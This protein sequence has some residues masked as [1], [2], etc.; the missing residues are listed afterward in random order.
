MARNLR[1]Y[2]SLTAIFG[3]P[4]FCTREHVISD[5]LA[6]ARAFKLSLQEHEVFPIF[7]FHRICVHYVTA[8]AGRKR[9]CTEF[10]CYPDVP[11]AWTFFRTKQ[12][13]ALC[14]YLINLMEHANASLTA[15][16]YR[17]CDGSSCDE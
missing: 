15:T 2:G 10:V 11:S 9:G 13:S 5:G 3:R 6:H 8:R 7:F 4:S 12:L 16:I 17:T 14:V 1:Y